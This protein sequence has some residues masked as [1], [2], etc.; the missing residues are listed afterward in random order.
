LLA[1]W[2]FL[3][4]GNGSLWIESRLQEADKRLCF[5]EAQSVP[6]SLANSTKTVDVDVSIFQAKIVDV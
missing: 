6:N 2:P 1:T 4:A 3:A 5:I